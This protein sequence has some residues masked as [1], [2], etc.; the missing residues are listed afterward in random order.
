MST[1]IQFSDW[2]YGVKS[3]YVIKEKVT[4]ITEDDSWGSTIILIGGQVKV[5]EEADIVI[6]R[7]FEDERNKD[8]TSS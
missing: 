3:V 8:E 4:A 2:E 1:I 6:G 5:R 7:L